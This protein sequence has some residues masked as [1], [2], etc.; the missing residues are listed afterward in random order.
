M[1]LMERAFKGITMPQ[2]YKMGSILFTFGIIGAGINA[3]LQWANLNLGGQISMVVAVF[4]QCLLLTLFLTLYFQFKKSAS[5]PVVV[6][7]P[8]LE[9]FLK[10]LQLDDTNEK[11]GSKKNGQKNNI[12]NQY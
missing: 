8:E 6:E 5:A 2:F 11:G 1:K 10:E 12:K 7:N 4:F 9:K 3:K